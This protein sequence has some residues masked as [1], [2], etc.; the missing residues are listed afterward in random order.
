MKYFLVLAAVLAGDPATVDPRQRGLLSYGS[1]L[2]EMIHHAASYAVRILKG[3]PLC[4]VRA[5]RKCQVRRAVAGPS[6]LV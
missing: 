5:R 3:D 4:A 1:N 6:A 2:N